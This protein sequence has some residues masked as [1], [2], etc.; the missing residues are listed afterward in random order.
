MQAMFDG[1]FILFCLN[2]HP[3]GQTELQIQATI[4]CRFTLKR[5]HDMTRT[6]KQHYL[7]TT[8]FAYIIYKIFTIFETSYSGSKFTV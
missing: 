8:L 4:E 2:T 7:F 3:F 1:K 5:V 6:Y